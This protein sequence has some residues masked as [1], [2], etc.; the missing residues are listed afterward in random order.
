MTSPMVKGSLIREIPEHDR[1]RERLDRLG[2]DSLTDAELL[3]ILIRTGRKGVSAVQL[4]ESLIRQFGS[5]E[6]VARKSISEIAAVSGMGRTKA[7]TLKAAF[8]IHER[9]QRKDLTDRPLKTPRD[10]Y[11]RMA[12]QVRFLDVEVLYGLALDSKL[13][14]IRSY[15][16]T[17]GLL[18]QTLV[19]PREVFREAIASS[20]AHLVLVHNHPSGDPRP[21]MDDIRATK[22]L[23]RAGEV[24]GIELIDHVVVGKPSAAYPTGFVSLKEMGVMGGS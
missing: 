21:S 12:E 19:H 10:I 14:L 9:V 22:D 7:V 23:V 11:E 2:A 6:G 4:A 3:A 8:A 1:P 5:L 18:N 20:A 16:I 15:V 13:K 24:L 17:R